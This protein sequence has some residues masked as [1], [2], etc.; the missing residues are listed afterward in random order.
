MHIRSSVHAHKS[1]ISKSRVCMH[2]RVVLKVECACTQEL[3]FDK[4]SVQAH[5]S[6]IQWKCV[7]RPPK[8]MTLY[9]GS[10]QSIQ[11]HDVKIKCMNN[12]YIQ[13]AAFVVISYNIARALLLVV[14]SR[15]L[16]IVRIRYY[17][18]HI[19]LNR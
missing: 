10:G 13:N 9:T 17:N 6:Y 18:I 19:D 2:T 4:S 8:G 16:T 1:Y 7:Y 3:Y 5:K 11:G 15:Y 12:L 14:I